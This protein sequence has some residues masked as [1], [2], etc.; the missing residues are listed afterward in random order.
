[1]NILCNNFDVTSYNS[2]AG[3]RRFHGHERNRAMEWVGDQ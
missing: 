3:A 2:P 1:M